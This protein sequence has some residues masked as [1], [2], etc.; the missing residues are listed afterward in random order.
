MVTKKVLLAAAAASLGTVLLIISRTLPTGDGI[1]GGLCLGIGAALAVLGIGNLVGYS[2][3]RSVETPEIRKVSLREENDERNIRVR[4]KAG[5]NAGRVMLYILCFVA[6]AS[7]FTGAELYITGLFA[8]LVMTE[9]LL[10]A[11]FL[12]YY[13]KRM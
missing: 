7:A 10:T 13:D 2:V 8:A 5:W 11:G 9:G 12:A 6:L 1:T 3:G 4:E